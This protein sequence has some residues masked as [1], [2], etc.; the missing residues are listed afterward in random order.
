[1]PRA[2]L[3]IANPKRG[4]ESRV[5]RAG[6]YPYYAGYSTAFVADALAL[7]ELSPHSRVL[8][9]WN[10]SGTTTDVAAQ[11]GHHA[12]GFDLNPTMV[13]VAKARLLDAT[14]QPSLNAI[15]HDLLTKARGLQP[16]NP[17]EPL[18][19]WFTAGTAHI[20]RN[21]ERAIQLLLISPSDYRPLFP[22]D[23]LGRVSALA[24]FF[25]VGLFRVLRKLLS[26]F[27]S[28]NPTWVK[29]PGRVTDRLTLRED[30]PFT[31]F[32]DQVTEMAALAREREFI[33]ELPRFLGRPLEVPDTAVNTEDNLSSRVIRRNL[34]RLGFS[35]DLLKEYHPEFDELVKRRCS[36]GHGADPDPV[37][38]TDYS[39]LQTAIFRAM[40]HLA[41]SV[42]V[43]VEDRSF[44]RRNTN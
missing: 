30:Q 41:L 22:L 7:A 32:R 29:L 6:W 43:A 14:V 24:A 27:R 11:S 20:F 5:G 2:Q 15:L 33:S 28:A 44:V 42:A 25:Y 8:D 13:V 18:E 38:E 23:S 37:K 4:K 39:R 17:G 12:L 40:D 31:L 3:P 19:A 34:Y 9:P 16:L 36:I 35:E 1:M 10:G 21:L 26:P